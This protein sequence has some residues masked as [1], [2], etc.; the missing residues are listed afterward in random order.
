[1]E[2]NNRNQKFLAVV[3][4]GQA[5][6][7][8]WAFTIRQHLKTAGL[9]QFL[10]D[11]KIEP[12]NSVKAQESYSLLLSSISPG[13]IEKIL[14]CKTT[15]EVWTHF[16]LAYAVKTSNVK[17]ELLREL[18][19][20]KCKRVKDVPD[21]INKVMVIKGRLDGLSVTLDDTM[22]ISILI[23]ALP[24]DKYESF[25]EAWG[26]IEADQ[27]KLPKFMSKLQ[28]KTKALIDHEL[29]SESA[30]LALRSQGF[31]GYWN[32]RG[33]GGRGGVGGQF[34]GRPVEGNS[35]Q[36]GNRSS[37]PCNYC[38]KPGH[39]KS[40]CFKLKE[41]NKQARPVALEA[42][43]QG[44]SYDD[45][46]DFEIAFVVL[47]DDSNQI[48]ASDWIADSGC[49]SHMTPNKH[50]LLDYQNFPKPLMIRIG[51]DRL[52]E[53]MGFGVIN[54]DFGKLSRVYYVPKLGRNLFSI[55]AATLGK[56]NCTVDTNE[57]VIYKYG[58]VVLRAT[59]RGGGV[60]M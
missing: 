60:L 10:T 47:E 12:E 32:Q 56:A 34:E 53:A 26:M 33:R 7:N 1:M 57:M 44:V 8:A 27:Q 24:A 52:I 28:E 3:L 23:N 55:P 29:E 15:H 14:H 6:Y 18:N 25:L 41:K 40:E 59:R 30:L 58:Q 35:N 49:S 19:S 31:S 21:A 5:N 17:L 9:D 20:I 48:S 2:L 37:T 4:N 43:E 13:E 16:E 51:D 39:W 38:H 45:N 22:I 54:T 46:E 11:V 42:T 36:P 50:W